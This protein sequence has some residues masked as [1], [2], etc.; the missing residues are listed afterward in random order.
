[1]P[2]IAYTHSVREFIRE[3][4]R[5]FIPGRWIDRVIS[6]SDEKFDAKLDAAFM[7]LNETTASAKEYRVG[8]VSVLCD[9]V[10]RVCEVLRLVGRNRGY[11]KYV[12]KFLS[13]EKFIRLLLRQDTEKLE[14]LNA[15]LEDESK[16]LCVLLRDVGAV[17]EDR[18]PDEGEAF[19]AAEMKKAN[20]ELKAIASDV[21]KTLKA[22]FEEVRSGIAEVGEKVD[23]IRIS[24]K[25]RSRHSEDKVAFCMACVD[26]SKDNQ[27]LRIGKKG[28]PRL[29]DVFEYYRRKLEE[30]GVCALAEFQKIVHAYRARESRERIRS[31]PSHLEAV[32][33]ST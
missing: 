15:T 21:A 3:L 33:T 2:Q 31:L 28:K 30:H 8:V 25:R 23:R 6:D 10:S 16:P 9:E 11:G 22:G 32:E 4:L 19:G 12:D 14:S 17:I 29:K 7:K 24:R 26:A 1:M 5:R 20:A 27:T 13:T 18:T